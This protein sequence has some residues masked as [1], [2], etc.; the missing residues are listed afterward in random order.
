VSGLFDPIAIGGVEVRNRTVMT[1]HGPRLGQA[2]Y[3]RYL[4]ERSRGGVGLVILPIVS[5]LYQGSAY[6]RVVP[7]VAGPEED[8]VAPRQDT[9]EGLT[10]F[11]AVVPRLRGQAEA[12][13]RG[14]AT[15]FGQLNH[16]GANRHWEN[17]Q[18]AVGPS[19]ERGEH[20]PNVPHQLDQ[21]EI[22]ELVLA[23]G[24]DARRALEAGLEGIE[25]HAAHGYLV[26]QFLSILH[27][28]RR[29]GYGGSLEGR[30][31]FLQEVIDQVRRRTTPDLPVGVRL[32][33]HEEAPAV[34]RLLEDRVSFVDISLGSF[35]GMHAGRPGL[36]YVAP[37]PVA[38]GP[39]LPF[40]RRV[41]EV[42]SMPVMVAGRIQSP[43]LARR[44]VEEGFADMVG[45]T[46][47][48]IADPRFVKKLA[49][50]RDAEVDLCIGCMECHLRR[51]I[52]C[53]V[54][55]EAGREEELSA[56]PAQAPKRVAVV[57]GGPAG[58]EAA[59]RAA[60]RGYR[61]TLF[62]ARTCLGGA[63]E[64]FTRDPGRAGWRSLLDRFARDLF[65][66][67]VDVRLGTETRAADLAGFD[68][69]VTATGGAEVAAGVTSASVLAG[70]HLPSGDV[71]VAMG[72]D[73]GLD[74]PMT[75]LMLAE[76]GCRVRLATEGYVAGAAL[77]P[78][79]LHVVT[80]RLL[81]E[82]VEL[83]ALT[84]VLDEASGLVLENV[85]T[86]ARR[87][88]EGAVVWASGRRSRTELH[89]ELRRLGVEAIPVGDAL[90]PRRLAHAVLDG[91]R[92]G[93]A[94]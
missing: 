73:D 31:R 80:R 28:R 69:V 48:L 52:T 45:F 77:E 53:P 93:N 54:N 67:G 85:L 84:R 39:A 10:W 27:N 37:F 44:V 86:G 83:T 64:L 63:L 35:T 92:V 90:A 62:E 43:A 40:A 78:G 9:A 13:R 70:G 11:D 56:R 8:A 36:P 38:E 72:L 47:A 74:G 24:E 66:A 26:A 76:R 21:G 32:T 89:D 82:G 1:T 87:H 5:A 30:A 16:P 34:A 12:V 14:G 68:V 50:G 51:V 22:A 33:A 49:E 41:R 75:A 81:E 71:T 6:P 29:D 2:R 17:M 57:G 3:E 7:A 94:L 91:A 58:L 4:E 46:R 65:A 79:L 60:R 18:P 15:V 20:P 19:Q 25:I 61:V 42:V 59:Y 88:V 23:Y 55:P